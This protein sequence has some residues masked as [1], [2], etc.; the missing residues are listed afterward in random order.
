MLVV[1]LDTGEY[2]DFVCCSLQALRP[3]SGVYRETLLLLRFVAWIVSVGAL[4]FP[5]TSESCVARANKHVP[6]AGFHQLNRYS[7]FALILILNVSSC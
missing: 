2:F 7:P 6:N 3:I 1:F 5:S 4:R